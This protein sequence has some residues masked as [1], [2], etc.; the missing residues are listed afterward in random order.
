MPKFNVT[1]RQRIEKVRTEEIKAISALEAR[2]EA[3]RMLEKGINYSDN[4]IIVFDSKVIHIQ[5]SDI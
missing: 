2:L 1:F 5:R 3:N 4:D